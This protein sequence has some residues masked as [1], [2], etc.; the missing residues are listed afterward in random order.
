MLNLSDSGKSGQAVRIKSRG[1]VALGY[2]VEGCVSLE[3]RRIFKDKVLNVAIPALMEND[4]PDCLALHA[5]A[6]LRRD[7]ALNELK[8][9]GKRIPP[10][11]TAESVRVY[12]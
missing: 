1:E 5:V 7:G 6:P 4:Y 10:R 3:E 11:P 2:F 9:K 12:L 8:K